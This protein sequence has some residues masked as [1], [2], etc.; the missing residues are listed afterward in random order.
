MKNPSGNAKVLAL[1]LSLWGATAWADG[2]FP[3]SFAIFAPPGRQ[4][5]IVAANFGLLF[6]SDGR[7]GWRFVCETVIGYNAH[8]YQVGPAPTF[9]VYAA[10][11]EGIKVGREGGCAWEWGLGTLAGASATDVFPDPAN[12][13][14]VLAIARPANPDHSY[15]FQG[16]YESWDEGRTF[17]NPLLVAPE[18][19]AYISGVEIARSDPQ[20]I[21][22]TKSI[23]G[24]PL[25]PDLIRSKDGG[26]TWEV[27]NVEPTLGPNRVSI[28]AVHPT[29]PKRL[30]LRVFDPYA[31]MD[32]DRLAISEDGGDT[33]RLAVFQDSGDAGPGFDTKLSCFLRAADGTLYVCTPFS[34]NGVLAYKSTDDG[35]T[36]Q[37]LPGV[38][39][40][41]ALAERD[42]VLYGATDDVVD[43]FSVATSRDQGAT[44]GPL[45]RFNEMCGPLTCGDTP[46]VC[47][48]PWATLRR[49]F[50]IPENACS[51][52]PPPDAGHSGHEEPHAH[53]GCEGSLG[54]ALMLG[55]MLG[56]MALAR[57]SSRW[58]AR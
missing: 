55:A 19:S 51:G 40:L 34:A 47:A 54:P 7:S 9:N 22:V 31:A 48:A 44:W 28:A 6:S 41:R 32:P 39:H 38:P 18:S 1:L 37:P 4:D 46:S 21:Y 5:V 35:R 50:Q 24:T 20:T 57:R 23:A 12:S 56:V 17:G 58:S 10:S 30:Y 49:Q 2:A 45:M 13:N 26:K 14:H 25:H 8:I 33:F 16:V 29:D 53:C 27:V 43:N 11:L 3:E 15:G 42:G 52:E 36:F